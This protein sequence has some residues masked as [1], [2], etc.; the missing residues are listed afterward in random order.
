VTEVHVIVPE[1]IDDPARPSGGNTYDRRVCDGLAV[2]GWSVREHHVPGEWPRPGAEGHAA[3]VL[4]V[5][6]IPDGA[7]VLVDGLIGSAAPEALVRGALR[8]RQ[9]VLVHTPLGHRPPDD[10]VA[11]VRAREREVLG[12]AA[13]VVTTSA[14]TRRRLGELYAL[15]ADRVHVAEP[16]VDAAGLAPGTGAGDALLCVAAV[17]PDK[18]HDVLL[19]GLATATDLS[20]RCA[21]VGSLDRDPAFAARVLCRARDSGLRDRVRF[22]GP[23]TGSEL[24]RAYA[25]A[26]LLVLASRAES[27]GMVVTEALARGLPVL[28]AEVGGV[29]EALGHGDDGTRPG[30]L[31]PPGDPA[32]LGAALRRWLLDAELRGRLRRAARERRASLRPWVATTSK[33]AGVLMGVALSAEGGAGVVAGAAR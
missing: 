32:A 17:T 16:G 18:G 15:P 27:Y 28:A 33:V 14:W 20:W 2:L 7:V 9:V 26:D 21:C 4:A 12:A 29:P 5:R 24:D 8:L 1:A 6:R 11:V 3:L 19:D 25:D 30:L 10:E 23:R 22:P 13:A 31:V